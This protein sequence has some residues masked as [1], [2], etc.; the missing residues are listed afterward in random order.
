M[1]PEKGDS[2]DDDDDDDEELKLESYHTEEALIAA[3]QKQLASPPL[4]AK[5]SKPL[6]MNTQLSIKS[7][8][9][10]ATRLASTNINA[11]KSFK[12]DSRKSGDSDEDKW[13]T[14]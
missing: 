2:D 11:G 12:E 9:S 10:G 14:N 4:S 8:A 3:Q 7:R 13:K 5:F 1:D 6:K